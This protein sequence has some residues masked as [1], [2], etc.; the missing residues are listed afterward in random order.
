VRWFWSFILM[1]V[2][3]TGVM[4]TVRVR[5]IAAD[6]AQ[7]AKA[8]AQASQSDE[9]S[10]RSSR[11]SR[12]QARAAQS[13]SSSDKESNVDSTE[14]VPTD[15]QESADSVGSNVENQIAVDDSQGSSTGLNQS[16]DEEELAEIT[17]ENATET[18]NASE[19][20]QS[21]DSSPGFDQLFDSFV[22]QANSYQSKQEPSQEDQAQADQIQDESARTAQ[23]SG[24]TQTNNGDI[25]IDLPS[26]E[27]Q[28]LNTQSDQQSQQE[29]LPTYEMLA[30]GSFRVIDTGVIIKGDGSATRPYVLNWESLRAVEKMYNPKKGKDQLPDWLDLLDGKQVQ[31]EG[32]TLVPVIATTTRELIVMMNPWDGCCIGIPP[33]PYDAI[34]VTLDHDVDFGNSAVGFGQVEGVFILDP[35]V[36][37]GWVLGIFIIEEAQY[38][39]GEGIAFPDF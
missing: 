26:D 33:S 17:T 31:I 16:T 29:S 21:T 14:S 8:S 13:E 6:Q 35:Y 2:V 30:N 34:E 7:A 10:S 5:T 11:R 27:E 37:D 9:S 18:E 15:K 32:H 36:V 39:S 20:A 38:R 19:S 22:T 3:F 12:R 1:L 25:V 24:T 28:E 23:D 4:Y